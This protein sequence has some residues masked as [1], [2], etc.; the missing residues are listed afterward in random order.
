[1]RLH[2]SKC[3]IVGNYVSFFISQNLEDLLR[4]KER[5]KKVS[6]RWY[7]M[8]NMFSSCSCF[9]LYSIIT[10]LES[11]KYHIFENIL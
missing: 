3:Q 10:P 1:M 9:N 2:L 6:D 8:Q 4:D 11:L 5:E 7:Y